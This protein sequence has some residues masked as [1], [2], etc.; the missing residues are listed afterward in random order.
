M[1]FRYEFVCQ[2]RS[3]INKVLLPVVADEFEKRARGGTDSHSVIP[4]IIEELLASQE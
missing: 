2:L 1:S 4:P 3:Q